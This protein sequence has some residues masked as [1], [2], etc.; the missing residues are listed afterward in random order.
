MHKG[1]GPGLKIDLVEVKFRSSRKY[2]SFAFV[3]E[4]PCIKICQ[5]GKFLETDN[6]MLFSYKSKIHLDPDLV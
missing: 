4:K 3:F 1:V 5:I 2:I 6:E